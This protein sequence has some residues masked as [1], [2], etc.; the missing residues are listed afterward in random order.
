[1]PAKKKPTGT[2]ADLNLVSMIPVF[3]DEDK[4]RE[5]LENKRWANGRT[6]PRCQC[7]KTYV[8]TPK[9]GSKSPVRPGVYKC[10]GCRK[11]FTVRIGTI[12]EDSRLPLRKW[13]MAIHLMC[14][15]K[16]GISS[17][18]IAR[19]LDVT[20][21]TA[22]FV[23]HRLRE[24]MRKEPMAGMLK[25]HVEADETYV[26]GKPRYKGQSKPG[27]GTRKKPVAVLVERDGN[28]VAMPVE[29]VDGETLK[30]NITSLVDKSS[31]IHT[32]E[33]PSY[34]GLHDAFEGGH[35]VVNHSQ[36]EYVRV[37]ECGPVFVSTNT[38]E[39][40]FARLKRSHYGI[41][42]QMSAKHL[43][44]YVDECAFRWDTRKLSDG[45]RMVATIK[46]AEGKRLTYR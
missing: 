24:A 14:A 31:T 36:K 22:W 28:A 11:Q 1:M 5:F 37:E 34:S 30:G 4:A 46:G 40:F 43:H 38:A 26:G 39:S 45:D 42:H 8:L 15:S 2:D 32:D 10:S 7:E 44:R 3:A 6:C 25:G 33:F 17:H 29:K 18:Q 27:R 41:H 16:K 21:K 35:K 19:E 23:C 12:F 20:Q 9:K 13:L